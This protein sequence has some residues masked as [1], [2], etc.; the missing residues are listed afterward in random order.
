MAGPD[1]RLQEVVAV[2]STECCGLAELLPPGVQQHSGWAKATQH[3]PNSVVW[4]QLAEGAV[5][6]VLLLEYTGI[7]SLVP[8]Q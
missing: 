4:C 6:G 8:I 2:G 3:R 5:S 7:F 1:V